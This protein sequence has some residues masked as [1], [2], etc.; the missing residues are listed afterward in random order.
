MLLQNLGISSSCTLRGDRWYLLNEVWP[1]LFIPKHLAFD[2]LQ[3]DLVS[4]TD[5]KNREQW[6]KAYQSVK[7]K[8]R[9]KPLM[10]DN[11]DAIYSNPEYYAGY[12]LKQIPGNMLLMGDVPSE[13]NHSS[14]DANLG[15]GAT[16]DVAEHISL[17]FQYPQ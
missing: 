17:L 16:W 3:Q 15:K 14:V 2:L 11:L 8:I 13:Q 6:D 1:K 10:V 5:S 7:N 9:H 12:Y 4:M